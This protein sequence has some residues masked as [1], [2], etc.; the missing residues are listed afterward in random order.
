MFCSYSVMFAYNYRNGYSLLSY[1]EYPIILVQQIVLIVI[2]A[3][4]KQSFS[5]GKLLMAIM[6]YFT[7]AAMLSGVIPREFI[8]FLAV[9][10]N[11]VHSGF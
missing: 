8:A 10:F 7:I 11:Q 1:L 6:Y 5:W 3:Y 4:Y 2:V 9:S